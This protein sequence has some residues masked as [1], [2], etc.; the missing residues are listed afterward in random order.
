MK[1]SDQEKKEIAQMVADILSKPK[2]VNHNWLSLRKDIED[3]CHEQADQ[4]NDLSTRWT[5]LQAKVYDAIRVVI[6]IHRISDMNDSQIVEARK[7][8]EFIKQER[9]KEK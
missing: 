4:V 6:S 1:L 8:F 7:V 5:T 3:W 9:E 2:E